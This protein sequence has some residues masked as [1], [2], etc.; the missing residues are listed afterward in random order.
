MPA[1]SSKPKAHYLLSVKDYQPAL[2]R[3]L[4]KS[5]WAQPPVLDRSRPPRTAWSG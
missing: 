1:T 5:P 3:Q 4:K 2:A